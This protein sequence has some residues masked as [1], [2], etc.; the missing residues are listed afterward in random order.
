M[1]SLV[2]MISFLF[3]S[4]Q[5][6]I[7]EFIP[8]LLYFGYTTLMVLSFWLLTGTIGFYAAY[9]FIRKIY[10][11]VK[12]DWVITDAAVPVVFFLFV[13]WS[14]SVFFNV[15]IFYSSCPTSTDLCAEGTERGA[16][17]GAK[18]P[19]TGLIRKNSKVAE[20]NQLFLSFPL[21]PRFYPHPPSRTETQR[22]FSSD[23]TVNVLCC[24]IL[25]TTR[26]AKSCQMMVSAQFSFCLF[27]CVRSQT[28]PGF[29]FFSQDWSLI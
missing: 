12:I 11:A 5:L 1:I 8:S 21:P 22:E 16:F 27:I 26:W 13:F 14:H 2:K 4:L 18:A 19:P 15:Y 29:N 3:I 25:H 6:D 23:E 20:L 7:V 24:F 28:Y 17:Y 9:M 10:A